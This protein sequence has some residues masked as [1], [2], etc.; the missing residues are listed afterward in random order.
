MNKACPVVIRKHNNEL[1]FLAFQH[2]LAGKQ[3]VKGTIE[4]GESVEQACIREL[5][6][7]SG[8]QGK[9]LTY[10]GDWDANFDS[11]VWGFCLMEIEGDIP[12]TFSYFTLDDGGH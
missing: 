12:D 7:E 4:A 8:L 2:P 6:E 5:A 9:V 11:Q 1:Q 3:I 10:L